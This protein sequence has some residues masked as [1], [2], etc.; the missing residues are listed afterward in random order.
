MG[1]LGL[2]ISFVV[3]LVIVGVCAALVR[4]DENN[5]KYL[6]SIVYPKDHVIPKEIIQTALNQM[7]NRGLVIL[8]LSFLVGLAF[9]AFTGNALIPHFILIIP[10]IINALLFRAKMDQLGKTYK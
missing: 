5:V 9:I 4:K 10:I 2:S 1:Y 8:V 3:I 6:V 7:L